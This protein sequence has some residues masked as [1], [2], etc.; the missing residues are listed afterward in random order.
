MHRLHV[1]Q[2]AYRPVTTITRD[3]RTGRGPWAISPPHC[4]CSI[5][6][7]ASALSP[8]WSPRPISWRTLNWE[9]TIPFRTCVRSCP[10][11]WRTAAIRRSIQLPDGETVLARENLI[12]RPT[13][14]GVAFVQLDDLNAEQ[15][16]RVRAAVFIIHDSRHQPRQ[17]S[18]LD[19]GLGRSQ[20]KGAVQGVYAPRTQRRERHRAFGG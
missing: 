1:S 16:N 9:S 10:Q 3:E 2:A 17:P 7:P 20:G 18:S 12:I 13:G 5:F 14:P 19:R 4:A 11:W 6:S 8:S 15:L